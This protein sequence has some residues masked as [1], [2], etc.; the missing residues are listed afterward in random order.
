VTAPALLPY[1]GVI[2]FFVTFFVMGVWHGSTGVF[3]IYGLVMGAG[4]SLNKL[5]QV[6]MTKRLG[7]KRYKSVGDS[8]AYASLARGLMFAFFSLAVTGL[9]VN[10]DQLVRLAHRL[11]AGGLALALF[12][13]ALCAA[14]GGVLVDHA[15][16]LS[17]RLAPRLDRTGVAG[18]VTR[19]LVLASEVLL[20]LAVGSFFHKAPEFVYKAF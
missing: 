17:L 18:V 1:L 15:G 12:G 14:V 10:M 19:N 9:W 4:A 5:W 2:A 6:F 13:I 11:G 16:R 3:V 7:K 8:F 20:I